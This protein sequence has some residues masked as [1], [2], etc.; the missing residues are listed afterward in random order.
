MV[1]VVSKGVNITYDSPPDLYQ[2]YVCSGWLIWMV[3]V[4]SKGVNITSDSLP[5]L[6]QGYIY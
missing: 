6:Y 4:V 3:N 1:K 5:D 2:G